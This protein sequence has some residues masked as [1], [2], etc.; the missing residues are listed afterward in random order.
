MEEESL[1][2]F[3]C[4]FPIKAVGKSSPTFELVVIEIIRQHVVELSDD[5]VTSKPSRGGKYTSVTV[6]IEA[7]SKSQLNAIYQALTDCPEVIMAL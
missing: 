6:M 2:A 3:P 5:A 1:L 4:Q 7:M